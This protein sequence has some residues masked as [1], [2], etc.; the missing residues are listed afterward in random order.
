L[1]K[2]KN[3]NLRWLVLGYGVDKAGDRKPQKALPKNCI[4]PEKAAGN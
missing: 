2:D 1:L 3:W 4:L